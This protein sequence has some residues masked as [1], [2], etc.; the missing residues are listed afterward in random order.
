M[1]SRIEKLKIFPLTEGPTDR[2]N[3]MLDFFLLFEQIQQNHV[4]FELNQSRLSNSPNVKELSYFLK[5]C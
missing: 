4:M 1:F 2:R 5:I 3:F